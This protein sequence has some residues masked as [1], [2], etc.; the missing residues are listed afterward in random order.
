MRTSGRPRRADEHD[1][2]AAERGRVGGARRGGHGGAARRRG[3]C[4]SEGV[5]GGQVRRG[6]AAT[7]RE[8]G[9]VWR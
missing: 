6:P 9:V 7:M 2:L 1:V 4:D 5:V 3:E 8:A